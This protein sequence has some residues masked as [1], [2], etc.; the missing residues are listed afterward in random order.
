M[1]TFSNDEEVY[2]ALII[3]AGVL[4]C[5]LAVALARQGRTVLLLERNLK[6]P[7]RIVGELLQPGGVAALE[8]LGMRGCLEGIDAIP[9]KGYEI[10]YRGENIT[11]WYPPIEMKND[12]LL[13]ELQN[14]DDYLHSP[15]S[16]STWRRPQG[17]SFHHGRFIMKLR[18]EAQ[19]EQRVR[20][21]QTTAKS[22]VKHENSGQVIGVV[23]SAENGK[24]QE[25]R[26]S[27]D[28]HFLLS[29]SLPVQND[30]LFGEE[31]ILFLKSGVLIQLEVLR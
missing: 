11:F 4:G 31:N 28:F 10:F 23:C 22:L 12:S 16:L 20:V 8:Q 7:N 3:G 24:E 17:R 15:A 14:S 9:V 30:H 25:V 5:A 29:I 26:S 19:S 6:E 21:V 13:G 27:V 2:D 1:A 18:E